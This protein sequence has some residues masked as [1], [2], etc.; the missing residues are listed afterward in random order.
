MKKLEF[1]IIEVEIEN[2]KV[3]DV[4]NSEGQNGWCPVHF[5]DTYDKG[6]GS[7]TQ[8]EVWTIGIYFM[9]EKINIQMLPD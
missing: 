3:I 7:F 4:L 2:T 8:N 9:R 1:K 6:N 5:T